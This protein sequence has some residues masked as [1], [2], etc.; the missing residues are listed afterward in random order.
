MTG[1]TF[2]PY[3]LQTGVSRPPMA[4]PNGLTLFAYQWNQ[5][6]AWQW[7][8]GNMPQGISVQGQFVVIATASYGESSASSQEKPNAISV[9]DL[10]KTGDALDKYAYT[11]RVG[12]PIP[13]DQLAVSARWIVCVETESKSNEQLK[14]KNQIHIIQ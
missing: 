13:Y 10:K 8:L 11:Y 4:H 12:G 5:Q 2:V 7:P 9:F 6:L 1:D 3:H 14:G